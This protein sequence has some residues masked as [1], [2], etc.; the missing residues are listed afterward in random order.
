MKMKL[1][2][3]PITNWQQ[4]CTKN[5]DQFRWTR[6]NWCIVQ[7]NNDQMFENLSENNITAHKI[8]EQ[9]L[10]PNP[11]V[12]MLV[13]KV[14]KWIMMQPSKLKKAMK[15]SGNKKQSSKKGKSATI[16]VLPILTSSNPTDFDYIQTVPVPALYNTNRLRGTNSTMVDNEQ[17]KQNSNIGLTF[18]NYH[19]ALGFAHPQSPIQA[20]SVNPPLEPQIH[21]STQPSTRTQNGLSRR[22]AQHTPWTQHEHLQ[23]SV[24]SVEDTDD[25]SSSEEDD[26]LN[27]FG[28]P[29]MLTKMINSMPAEG[30]NLNALNFQ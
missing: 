14:S 7:G 22:K 3:D 17:T 30:I 27:R 23:A 13:S 10:G 19:L 12:L 5:T 15:A 26:E 25:S 16:P 24:G 4:W 1:Q 20:T 29:D 21:H 11:P 18:T 6:H 8:Q 2:K 28:S 9:S